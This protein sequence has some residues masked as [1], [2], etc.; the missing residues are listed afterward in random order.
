MQQ[1]KLPHKYIYLNKEEDNCPS[2]NESTRQEE[3]EEEEEE[4][5]NRDNPQ[6]LVGMGSSSGTV[7]SFAFVK[8]TSIARHFAPKITLP[9]YKKDVPIVCLPLSNRESAHIPP[10]NAWLR[11]ATIAQKGEVF[12]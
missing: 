6:N 7:S 3:E 2:L 5:R 8:D 1:K 12:Q 11:K 4:E 10:E 9:R